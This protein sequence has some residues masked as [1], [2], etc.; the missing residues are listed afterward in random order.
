MLP[1]TPVSDAA[2]PGVQSTLPMEIPKS[3]GHYIYLSQKQNPSSPLQQRKVAGETMP[4][5]LWESSHF[6]PTP[7]WLK[8]PL[9][10]FLAVGLQAN[11]FTSSNLFSHLENSTYITGLL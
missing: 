11:P 4:D 2:T 8:F 5:T 10:H 6:V 3:R 7:A 9:W 1:F